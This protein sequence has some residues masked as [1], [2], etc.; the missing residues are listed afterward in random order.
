M[1]EEQLIRSEG[2]Y[3]YSKAPIIEA[4]IDKKAQEKIER[5]RQQMQYEMANF[6]MEIGNIPSSP[7]LD[8]FYV[9]EKYETEIKNLSIEIHHL[10]GTHIAFGITGYIYEGIMDQLEGDFSSNYS[11][12][13]SDEDEESSEERGFELD[14]PRVGRT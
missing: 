12:D 4:S 14:V 9:L 6:N 8:D 2:I 13:S 5:V 3:F 10:V 1:I 7:K 11:N